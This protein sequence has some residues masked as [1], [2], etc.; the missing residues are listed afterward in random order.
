VSLFHTHARFRSHPA[1][2]RRESLI[3]HAHNPSSARVAGRAVRRGG[4]AVEGLLG[5]ESALSPPGRILLGPMAGTAETPMMRQYRAAKSKAPGALLFFRMGDFYELFFDDAKIASKALGLTLTSRSKETDIPMAG[6]PVRSVD[7]YLRRLVHQ[8]F[9]VAI[10]EQLENPATAKGIVDRDVVRI[11]T[12]G[13]LTEDSVLDEKAHNYLAAAAFTK[14]RVGLAWAELST[15]GFLIEDLPRADALDALAR[16]RPAEILL[17]ESVATDDEALVAAAGRITGAPPQSVPDWVLAEATATRTL[18]DHFGVATLEGFGLRKQDPSLAAAAAVLHYLAETQKQ[19]LT[20]ITALRR[21]RT[22]DHLVLDASTRARLDLD[23]LVRVLDFTATAAG[24]RLLRERLD[25][26]LTDTLEVAKRLDAVEELTADSFLRRDLNEVLT[27]IRDVERIVSRAA[28]GR[29]LPR[30]LVGLK[31]SLDVVPSLQNLLAASAAEVLQRVRSELDPVPELRDLLGR[32]LRDD[33]P[34]HLREGGVIRDGFSERLDEL[35]TL[36]RDGKSFIAQL[37]AREIERTGIDN[38]KVGYNRVFGYYIEVTH[39]HKDKVPSDYVRKQTL[40]NAERYITPEL[41]EHEQQVLTAEERALALEH[42]LFEQLREAVVAEVQRLQR[43]AGLVAE[44]D[45]AR[46]LAEAAAVRGYVRPDV[47]PGDGLEIDEGR[48]PVV[49]TALTEVRFVP[50][51]LRLDLTERTVAVITGPNMAGK[52]TYIRQAA[53]IVL[54][55]QAGSF[56]PAARARIGAA[57]RIF[58]RIGAEDDLA[59]GRSTFMVEMAETAHLANHATDRS[60]VILDEVGRGTSTFDGVAIAWAVTE[61][62]AQVVGCRT[63]F[64]THYHEL[65]ALADEIDN[66]FNLCVTVEEWGDDIVFLHRIQEGGTD[67]SYG[68]HVARL[69]GL[70]QAIVERA[71]AL[72]GGLNVRTEGLGTVGFTPPAPPEP[73]SKQLTFFPPP[74]EELRKALIKLDPDTM[75]PFDALARLRDLIRLVRGS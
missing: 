17:P 60:L 63:L 38:L 19:S 34:S 25:L 54:M 13:T 62:L 67:R 5:Q 69:A 36:R 1:L 21:F 42:K 68:I 33:P 16:I 51:D 58:T 61:Y 41:K 49:E 2:G 65:T 20:H 73:A 56:V 31:A 52:S 24:G 26:P 75:T 40:R 32:A 57:D 46:A 12:P 4:F 48:H 15:G 59:G 39:A 64:A 29:C 3:A 9:R 28:T 71:R 66:V 70:P 35:R 50:N 30:D 74:G 22:G 11:V 53:L 7:G 18:K 14:R 10:C 45:V 23:D 43:T 44:V 6:V 27:S 72:L 37:R 55:A 47:H 8:G